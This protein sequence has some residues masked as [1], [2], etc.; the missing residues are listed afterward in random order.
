MTVITSPADAIYDAASSLLKR[1]I[2]DSTSIP[3]KSAAIHTLGCCTFY[4]GASDDEILDNMIYFLEIVS[5]DGHY[6]S[7]P[8][9]PGPVVNALEEWGFLATLIEDLST[10]TEDAMEAFVEQLGSSNAVVQVA[11]GENIAL[12]YEKSYTPPEDNEILSDSDEDVI[13]DPDAEN[14]V[15]KLVKRYAAYRRTDQLLHTLSDLSKLS[16]RSLSKKDKKSIHT[17]FADIL[18]SVEHP[19]RGPRYQNAISQ[20]TGK[21]YGSRMAVRIHKDGVMRIDKWWKLM[22]LKGLRRVLQG[23]FITHYEKNGVVFES[24]PIMITADR[25]VEK[26]G[27]KD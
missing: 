17:N 20:E 10:E 21:R 15:P 16:T 14:D 19:T 12:L 25:A 24:L 22:R 27:R 3:T 26:N 18:N 13:A 23:G 8:D 4:G 11:A 9:E 1:T 6:I 2:S 7:A 5:S